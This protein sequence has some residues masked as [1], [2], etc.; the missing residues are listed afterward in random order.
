MKATLKQIEESLSTPSKY[1]ARIH[2]AS[3]RVSS[4]FFAPSGRTAGHY[5]KADKIAFNRAVQAV[6]AEE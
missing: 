1:D 4:A 5:T 6:L 3:I 2:N